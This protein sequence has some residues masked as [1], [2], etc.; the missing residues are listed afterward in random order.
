METEVWTKGVSYAVV[1]LLIGTGFLPIF[2]AL[3]TANT[4]KMSNINEA[5]QSSNDETEYWALLVAVGVYADNPEEDRPDMQMEVDDFH[6]VL[7]QSDWWSED[8]I[9]VL[10]GEDATIT[11][12]I[13]G[14]RWLDKMED[15]NDISVVYLSTHGFPLGVDIPPVDEADGTDEAL[16]SY[17]G[18]AY[19]YLFIWDD[20][21]NILLNR[22]ES[23][24][25]CLIVDS[26]Y[27]GGFNDPPNWNKTSVNSPSGTNNEMSAAEWVTGFGEDVQGQNRV[28]L[29]ASRE[30]ELSFSGGFGPYVIDG[31][32]G[33]ADT[34][35]D[36][37]VSAE[38]VFFYAQPRSPRQHPTMY[39]GFPSDLPLIT[40]N[41]TLQH[42]QSTVMSDQTTILQ[43]KHVT[44]SSD[45]A[46]ENSTICG[47]IKENGTENPI[48]NASV[49]VWGRINQW[50][51][52]ENQTTTDA[53]GF[54][55]MNIP[56][57]RFRL[58]VTA[59]GYCDETEGPYQINENETAWVNLSLYPRP[60]ETAMVCGYIT[61]EETT[62]PLEMAHVNLFWEGSENQSYRNDTVSD[63]NG[64]YHLSVAAGKI[65]LDV[66]RN[67]YFSES[68]EETTIGESEIVWFNVSL[69]P[70]P[71]ETAVLCGYITDNE[72]GDPLAGTQVSVQWID[73]GIG[74]EYGKDTQTN[75]SGFYSINIAP[76]ELY[77]DIRQEGYEY[78]DPYRHDGI[79]NTT[80][81]MN[82]SLANATIDVDIAK[83]LRAIYLNN[84]RVIPFMTTRIF[85]SIDIEAYIPGSWM[86][87][88]EAEKVEFYIDDVL[89][90]TI[91]TE[92]YTWTWSQKTIGKHVIKVIAYDFEGDSASKEIEVMKFL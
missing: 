23:K 65:N 37:V 39:D 34:N 40:V 80:V 42:S 46:V 17:W 18:F 55:R 41:A 3:S 81:W 61:D 30:D 58:T 26:C 31:V 82:V 69:Y 2:S 12:I 8:H 57:G 49:D 73:F 14:L 6:S 32:R 88:I 78:Y 89:Q 50:E 83:P 5:S 91:T 66:T 90:A 13:S 48:E 92:P 52:Y 7:L 19:P 51:Y 59:E 75:S 22:L 21:L 4:S 10:K 71:A 11:N 86:E 38:E 67:G 24:G 74:H 45:R 84:E 15:S 36:G 29:M 44:H 9:K 77:I 47:Y 25:V 33:Y 16:V 1:I 87:P 68:V 64:F 62:S 28:V 85:G 20:E 35:G 70:R 43:I 60:P 56:A 27:A 63:T 54:Y 72:T 53:S 76:G 79:E